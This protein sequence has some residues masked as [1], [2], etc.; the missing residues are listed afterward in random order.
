MEEVRYTS[1]FAKK[2]YF[3][4]LNEYCCV[5][6][7]QEQQWF[8]IKVVMQLHRVVVFLVRLL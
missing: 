2:N 8:Q 4:L 5:L 7:M 6:Q 1:T 3:F